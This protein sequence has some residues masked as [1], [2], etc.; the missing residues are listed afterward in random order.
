[1]KKLKAFTL[2]EL[3]IV[4]A[5]VGILAVIAAPSMRAM[6][7][8]S[9]NNSVS[10]SLLIDIMYTR[11]IAITNR[12]NAQMIPL[13]ATTGTGTLANGNG[14]NWAAGWIIIDTANPA[15]ILRSQS[16][17][18]PDPQ[19]RSVE[20]G[21]NLDSTR[22]I[23]FNSEGFSLNRG[24]L[25]VAVLGCAGDSARRLQ[26]NQVGQIIGTDILCPAGFSNQ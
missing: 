19:I 1:M 14:V 10:N 5:L 25:E 6:I 2:I 9:K 23:S 17:F 3:M 11:N 7:S 22:P 13:D 15:D 20:V 8:N 21:F 18:G 24:T 16:N 4:V 12:S 26:I